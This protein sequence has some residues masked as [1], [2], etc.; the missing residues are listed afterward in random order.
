MT[1][2]SATP[3]DATAIASIHVESW[4]VA[5][6]GQLPDDVLDDL[7]VDRRAELWSG[8]ISA[9]GPANAVLLSERGGVVE[10]FAHV[11]EARDSD[12]G[13]GVGEVSAIYLRPQAWG[14]GLGRELMAAALAR[15]REAG[16]RW[17]TLWVL[18]TN[19][20]ARR[21][22]EVG[23]WQV[24]GTERTEHI[25]GAPVAEVRYRRELRTDTPT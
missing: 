24:D 12:A 10:G 8:V 13:P 16:S 19:D 11:C 15:L 20:R 1:V 6:R 23:G 22:Y 5:Y 14:Q 25:G 3:R 17:A 18:S 21:F 9:N 2:R 4:R 7:S